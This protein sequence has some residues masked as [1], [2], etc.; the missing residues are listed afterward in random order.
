MASIV[1]DTTAG[2][3]EPTGWLESLKRLESLLGGGCTVMEKVV[4]VV[5]TDVDKQ[6]SKEPACFVDDLDARLCSVTRIARELVSLVERI[7]SK[8]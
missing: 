8:F 7:G 1:K 3:D 6:L 4:G 2:Q 5:P